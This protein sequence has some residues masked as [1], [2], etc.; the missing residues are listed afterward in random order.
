MIETRRSRFRPGIPVAS[1][2]PLKMLVRK[3]HGDA[4]GRFW[5]FEKMW[6]QA[7]VLQS[8]GL[9]GPLHAEALHSD[10]FGLPVAHHAPLIPGSHDRRQ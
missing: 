3:F 4:W 9:H 2:M 6:R 5:S 7:E 8:I 10:C 1:G